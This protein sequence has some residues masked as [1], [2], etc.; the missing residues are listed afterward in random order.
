MKNMEDVMAANIESTTRKQDD[1]AY[2]TSG[3]AL[4]TGMILAALVGIW[5]I[6]CLLSAFVTVGPLN[7]IKG[8]LAA[9]L[10]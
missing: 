9:L 4:G 10:G 7:V 1:V 5:G 6:V 8:Y 2:E 3:F